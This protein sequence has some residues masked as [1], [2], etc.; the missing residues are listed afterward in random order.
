[1]MTNKKLQIQLR[2]ST[3]LKDRFSASTIVSPGLSPFGSGGRR[4]QRRK[5]LHVLPR[6]ETIADTRA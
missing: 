6:E 2:R 1:M 4:V 3:Q 5:I